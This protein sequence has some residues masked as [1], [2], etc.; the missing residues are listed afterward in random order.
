MD[1]TG[2]ATSQGCEWTEASKTRSRGW[3]TREK[4]DSEVKKG[5]ANQ[6]ALVCL[7]QRRGLP[8]LLALPSL[9]SVFKEVSI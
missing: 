7:E 4:A 3:R 1:D 5:K 6:Q 8:H 2:G 9:A